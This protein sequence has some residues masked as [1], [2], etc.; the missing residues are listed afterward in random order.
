[1]DQL[2]ARTTDQSKA[3]R[4]M[5][6]RLSVHHQVDREC[7]S[8]TQTPS[9]ASLLTVLYDHLRIIHVTVLEWPIAAVCRHL[10]V[11]RH[12]VE[13]FLSCA[14]LLQGEAK[15]AEEEQGVWRS[16]RRQEDAPT[17]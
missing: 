14:E 3:L 12:L 9:P 16:K 11:H 4:A 2:R 17:A 15:L 8:P 1:M 10:P 5:P 6:Q 7:F 13:S